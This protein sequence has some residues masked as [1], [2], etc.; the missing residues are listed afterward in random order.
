MFR[1]GKG[2]LLV[3]LVLW[4]RVAPAQPDTLVVIH[5]N[6]THSHLVPYGPKDA[7]GIGKLG[8]IARAATVVR[9]IQA[10]ARHTLELH[11]GDLMVGDFMYTRF[12]GVPEIRLLLSLGWDAWTVGN[13]EFD[14]GPDFLLMSLSEAGVPTDSF[15]VISANLDLSRHPGLAGRIKPYVIRDYGS[16]KVGV[17]GLTPLMANTYSRPA[18]VVIT[19]PL[20]AA[21]AMIDTLRTRCDAIICLSH[22]G[23]GDDQRLAASVGGIDVIVGAHSHTVLPTAVAVA[24][25]AS[26]TTWIV[27]AGSHYDYV[28]T[29]RLIR[30][31]SRFRL[32]DYRLLPVDDTVPEDAEVAAV[33]AAL[34]D[35]L[36]AD[37]RY[38]DVY[39]EVVGE[40]LVD[41]DRQVGSGREKDTPVGNLI[42]DALREA[43]G[44]DVAIDVHGWISDKLWA[45]PITRA[46]LFHIAYYGLDPIT[47]HGFNV[48][49]IGLT[50]SQIRLGME[51]TLRNA[52]QD[53]DLWPEVSGMRVVYDSRSFLLLVKEITVGGAPLK[54]DSVYSV[55]VTDGLAAFLGAA[56]LTPVYIQ[57]VGI[58]EYEALVNFARTH[59]P[60]GYRLEGRIV[61]LAAPAGVRG[62]SVEVLG[63]FPLLQSWPNP[64][65]QATVIRLEFGPVPPE[66]FSLYILDAK[67]KRV[68]TLHEGPPDGR[69]EF[70]WDGSSDDATPLP[71]GLYLAILQADRQTA[72][73]KMLLLR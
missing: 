12:H 61:D 10:T 65:N 43:A 35:T 56:G 48:M 66:A 32:S 33:V 72:V 52:P 17:F 23:F 69:R 24:N 62:S 38:G 44:A 14:A 28:G 58:S 50:G 71:S 31:A 3:G 18:P 2:I 73:L 51:Y 1:F 6:D 55:A 26:D 27:Q 70:A 53:G 47:G 45:G 13:H 25:P 63:S 30:L 9:E 36:A 42:V 41:M 8:G 20:I 60:L 37:P 67:G 54:T 21:R 5:I 59:S 15:A 64:F 68:R 16:F 7:R 57:P 46:D 4:S 19:D 29:F 39:G 22:L 49:R 34:R 40:A 11:G